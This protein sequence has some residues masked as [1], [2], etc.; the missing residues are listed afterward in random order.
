V[1]RRSPLG[2]PAKEVARAPRAG[3]FHFWG[4]E[5]PPGC[6]SSC[7]GRER[8]PRERLPAPLT[9]D[10]GLRRLNRGDRIGM[11]VHELPDSVLGS[12]DAG[13]PQRNRSDGS[14]GGDTHAA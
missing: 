6:G 9:A 2:P 5:L 14:A 13:D 10:H 1:G 12:K 7:F 4:G 8:L 3:H 11:A